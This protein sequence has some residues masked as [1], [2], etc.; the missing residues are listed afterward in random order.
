[1]SCIKDLKSEVSKNKQAAFAS[2]ACPRIRTLYLD[3]FVKSR[4]IC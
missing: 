1:M 4:N 3:Q 2:I